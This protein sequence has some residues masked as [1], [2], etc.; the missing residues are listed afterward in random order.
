M[1]QLI[2]CLVCEVPSQNKRGLFATLYRS[3]SQGHNCLQTFL[4]EFEK[5]LSNIRKKELIL[6]W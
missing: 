2:E 3:P 5:L 1:S 6:L 4:R